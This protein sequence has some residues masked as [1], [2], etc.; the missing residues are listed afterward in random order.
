MYPAHHNERPKIT[1]HPTDIV[2]LRK[3]RE[4]EL[5]IAQTYYKIFALHLDHK[6]EG[7]SPDILA[8]MHELRTRA[9]EQYQE[10]NT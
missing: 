7:S 8:I 4:L 10:E 5:E 2:E 6:N 3:L 1:D 9:K